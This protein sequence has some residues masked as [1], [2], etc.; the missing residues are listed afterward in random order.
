MSK[1]FDVRILVLD[2]F[3]T[4]IRMGN[5]TLSEFKLPEM[6]LRCGCGKMG[7]YNMARAIERYGP[8]MQIYDFIEMKVSSVCPKW[9]S[10]KCHAG[11]DDLTYMFQRTPFT[12]EYG[13]D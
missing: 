9:Q 3:S 7:R 8:D 5:N 4:G 10:G 1:M 12:P 13:A 2:N 6:I 11:C